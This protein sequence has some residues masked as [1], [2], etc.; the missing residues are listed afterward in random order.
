MV[1]T[2]LE[3]LLK[4]KELST[5]TSIY[6]EIESLNNQRTA[7][8]LEEKRGKVIAAQ[9]AE[10]IKDEAELKTLTGKAHYEKEKQIKKGRKEFREQYL[11]VFDA[12]LKRTQLAYIN[13]KVELE[14]GIVSLRILDEMIE[15]EKAKPQPEPKK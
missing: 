2:R 9:E 4:C 15:E 14:N 7:T 13:K 10:A 11:Q 3:A 1:P 5:E 12:Q 8:E 6:T